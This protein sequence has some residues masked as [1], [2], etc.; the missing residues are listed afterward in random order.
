[1]RRVQ[2]EFKH[3]SKLVRGGPGCAGGPGCLRDLAIV[4]DDLLTW[5]LKMRD[6]DEDLGGGGRQLNQD[7]EQRH[8]AVD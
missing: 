6:F 2:A 3:L 7:L 4:D 1:M 5:R 8:A